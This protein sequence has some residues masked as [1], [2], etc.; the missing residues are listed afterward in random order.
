MRAG[1]LGPRREW[2][3]GTAASNFMPRSARARSLSLS[4]AKRRLLPTGSLPPVVIFYLRQILQKLPLTMLAGPSAAFVDR[5]GL[6]FHS[7]A[8]P[9]V[10]CLCLFAAK[11]LTVSI[12]SAAWARAPGGLKSCLVAAGSGSGTSPGT[13]GMP[14]GPLKVCGLQRLQVVPDHEP[15]QAILAQPSLGASEPTEVS[16]VVKHLE[17]SPPDLGNGSSGHHRDG[18]PVRGQPRSRRFERAWFCSCPGPQQL[19]SW[20]SVMPLITR[21]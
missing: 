16:Q 1:S 13:W 6:E 14:E 10:F 20:K 4:M 3:V 15:F 18:G 2:A 11:S 12:W 5:W 7:I 21:N 9:S 17:V 8:P 19:V